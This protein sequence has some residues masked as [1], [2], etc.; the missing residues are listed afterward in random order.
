MEGE[1]QCRINGRI[2]E[3]KIRNYYLYGIEMEV[4]KI[5]GLIAADKEDKKLG[6]IIKIEDIEDKKTKIPKTYALILVKNFLRK[7]V[8]ILM[9][10]EKLLKTDS[11]Y[12]WFDVFKKDFVQEV[13]ETRALIHLYE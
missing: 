9:E 4:N 8:V 2:L 1:N 12:V 6:K 13:N 11:Y 5:I 3:I 10:I 7:D